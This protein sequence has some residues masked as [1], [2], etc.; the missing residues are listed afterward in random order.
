[1]LTQTLNLTLTPKKNRPF[2]TPRY[3]SSRFTCFNFLQLPSIG[4]L[5]LPTSIGRVAATLPKETPAMQQRLH[6][7]VRAGVGATSLLTAYVPLLAREGGEGASVCLLSSV[8]S[9]QGICELC[10][11]CGNGSNGTAGLPLSMA[12][13]VEGVDD[14]VIQTR[15]MGV[16]GIL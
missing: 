5:T 16:V 3:P 7:G 11:L 10:E 8:L 15:G 12:S 1:M 14:L 13:D 6:S 9:G 4:Q 2:L